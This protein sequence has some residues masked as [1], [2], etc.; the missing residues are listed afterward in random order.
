[1]AE[2]PSDAETDAETEVVELMVPHGS[3]PTRLA[4]GTEP[5]IDLRSRTTTVHDPLTTGV[6]AEVAR[7]QVEDAKHGI[8]DDDDDLPPASPRL[9]KRR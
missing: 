9:I 7:R 4:A 6:L 5:P 1:M 2:Q 3:E 8:S